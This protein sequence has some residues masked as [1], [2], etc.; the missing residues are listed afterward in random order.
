[1][2]ILF[3]KIGKRTGA[4][5][6]KIEMACEKLN[7]ESMVEIEINSVEVLNVAPKFETTDFPQGKL[8][9]L[10]GETM[11]SILNKV[12]ETS[13][14][15]IVV[16]IT[17]PPVGLNLANF[18]YKMLNKYGVVCCSV[19]SDGAMEHYIYHELVHSIH[20]YLSRK[21]I[22]LPDTQD[23][24]VAVLG[25]DSTTPEHQAIVK[26]NLEDCLPYLDKVSWE[27]TQWKSTFT[28]LSSLI[29]IASRLVALVALKRKDWRKYAYEQAIKAGVDARVLVAVIE[30]ES[31][32]QIDAE[33]INR[34][35]NGKIVSLDYGICQINDYWTIGSNSQAA[36]KGEY[37][38]PSEEYVVSNPDKCIDWMIQQWLKGRQNDWIAY[39]TGA[40][41]KYMK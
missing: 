38:F 17:E 14:A 26:K 18:C 8:S 25:K 6:D 12:D 32:F 39:K 29:A 21:G 5:Q 35:K 19:V 20:E 11:Y 23:P 33:N 31:G 30:A 16:F 41:K 1:M 13:I 7:R 3:L 22:P 37:Y 9:F 34:D 15:P 10:S 36:M 24:E 4:E 2:K 28:L 40:Y 27:P